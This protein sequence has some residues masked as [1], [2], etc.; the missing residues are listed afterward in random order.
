MRFLR[1]ANKKGNEQIGDSVDIKAI[2]SCIFKQFSQEENKDVDNLS[3]VSSETVIN[4]LVQF[5]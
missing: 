1:R 4:N 2:E 5:V 3:A